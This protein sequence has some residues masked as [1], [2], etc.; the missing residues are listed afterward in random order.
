MLPSVPGDLE[1]NPMVQLSSVAL[2][3]GDGESGARVARPAGRRQEE[4]RDRLLVDRVRR[5]DQS[6]FEEL[7]AHYWDRIFAMVHRILHD[8][9]DAEE[10]TQDAFVRA[11]RHLAGFRGDSAFFTWLYEIAVNLARSRWLY[12]QRRG[13]RQTVSIDEPC[14]AEECATLMDAVPAE[15]ASPG[16][17]AMTQELVD[18]VALCLQK[19]HPRFRQVLVLRNAHHLSYGEIADA[20]GLKVNTVKS[21]VFRARESLRK[22]IGGEYW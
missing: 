22:K 10:V 6:A 9:R 5:G 7:I 3:A 1:A 11:Y 15:A 4:L 18:R 2:S 19:L 13:R 20:L 14:G 12:W 17:L 8:A 21:R 16:E